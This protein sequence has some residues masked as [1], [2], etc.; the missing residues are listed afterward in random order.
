[1]VRLLK[2]Q[3]QQHTDKIKSLILSG[4]PFEKQLAQLYIALSLNKKHTWIVQTYHLLSLYIDASQQARLY[5]PALLQALISLGQIPQ[6]HAVA[7]KLHELNPNDKETLKL[8]RSLQVQKRTALPVYT[9]LAN[10]S[11]HAQKTTHCAR[12]PKPTLPA[13]WQKVLPTI[14]PEKLAEIGYYSQRKKLLKASKPYRPVLVTL[15]DE[16][17][18]NYL[19][20]QEHCVAVVAGALLEVLLACQ[21]QPLLRTQRVNI[22]KQ[23]KYLFELN[24]SELL[25]IYT[26]KKLLPA[27]TLQLC[28][29]TRMQRNFIHPGKKI[30]ASHPLSIGGIRVCLLAVSEAID[31]LL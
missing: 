14:T 7:T 20:E 25:D 30:M 26:Q 4:L 10:L 21:L 27:S 5:H 9:P 8:I 22:G 11:K 31:T 1:M 2:T 24:L 23:N 29:A 15:F 3:L 16:M 6:A 13:R 28:Q 19:F 17:M 12:L 18:L